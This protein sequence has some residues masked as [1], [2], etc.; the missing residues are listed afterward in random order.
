MSQPRD[1]GET[2]NNAMVGAMCGPMTAHAKGIP[3]QQ[4]VDDERADCLIDCRVPYDLLGYPGEKIYHQH[5]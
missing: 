2:Q 4:P 5:S 3:S 1:T